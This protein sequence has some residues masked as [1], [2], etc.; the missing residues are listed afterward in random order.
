MFG[1]RHAGG[2]VE[3]VPAEVTY[4][5][6][7]RVLGRGASPADVAAADDDDPESGHVAHLADGVVVGTGTIR[8][9]PLPGDGAAGWQIRGMAVDVG[10]PSGARRSEWA[11]QASAQVGGGGESACRRGTMSQV[12]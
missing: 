1:P 4:E 6:R 10:Q 12:P 8:R 2:V 11:C 5:L 3:R 7:H 9:R